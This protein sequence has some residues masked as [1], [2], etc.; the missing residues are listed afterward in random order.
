MS[1]V[2]AHAMLSKVEACEIKLKILIGLFRTND[3]RTVLFFLLLP[4]LTLAQ[5]KA[6][7]PLIAQVT[8]ALKTK[9]DS[10]L[11][12]CVPSLVDFQKLVKL[13]GSS[14][15]ME[16]PEAETIFKSITKGTIETFKKT[17]DTGQKIGVDWSSIEVIKSEIEEEVEEGRP[18]QKA[19]I[20]ITYKEGNHLFIIKLVDCIKVNDQLKLMDRIWWY[21][22]L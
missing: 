20:Y 15:G 3:M 12:K 16:L 22:S 8:L 2:F 9:N 17:L 21:K 1:C 18:I 10:L 7:E 5:T 4:T 19:D 13:Q 14:S 6:E 11:Y